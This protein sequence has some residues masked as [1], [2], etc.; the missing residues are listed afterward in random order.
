VTTLLEVSDGGPNITQAIFLIIPLGYNVIFELQFS[1]GVP[2]IA[3]I[4]L[5]YNCF[6][7]EDISASYAATLKYLKK[8]SNLPVPQVFGFCR[9]SDPTNKTK[10]TYIFME[11]MTGHPLPMIEKKASE[12]TPA[13]HAVAK[14]VHQQLADVILQ[15]GKFTVVSL[16]NQ[17]RYPIANQTWLML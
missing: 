10:V 5:P 16:E 15:L 1:D 6:Q 4:P 17:Q 12:A 2:W 9:Q 3:R 7:P 14:K 8:H 11:K 13:E